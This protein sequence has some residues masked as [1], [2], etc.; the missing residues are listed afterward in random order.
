MVAFSRLASA[1]A[2]VVTVLDGIVVDA[3]FLFKRNKQGPVGNSGWLGTMGG[4]GG[5]GAPGGGGMHVFSPH[6]NN[7]GRPSSTLCVC[8]PTHLLQYLPSSCLTV[9]KFVW[10]D[11]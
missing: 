8:P 1:S 2:A 9:C 4:A 10:R 3:R 11:V 6:T 5:G 7:Y